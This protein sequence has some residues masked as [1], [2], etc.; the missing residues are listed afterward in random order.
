MSVYRICASTRS[1]AC[2]FSDSL[3]DVLHSVPG[4]TI[5]STGVLSGYL[6]FP[7]NATTTSLPAITIG[8]G[9]QTFDLPASK[10]LIPKP[11]YA[12]LNLTEGYAYSWL[13]SAGQGS[14]MLGQ[15]WLEGIYTAYDMPGKRKTL[16][17]L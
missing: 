17:F 16:T 9:D 1:E 13:A 8:L 6:A 10:Y 15:K 3:F 12:S 4:A 2:L 7:A 5:V 14:F 11:L